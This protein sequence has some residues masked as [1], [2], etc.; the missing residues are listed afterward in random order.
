MIVDVLAYRLTEF[1]IY[2]ACLHEVE[3]LGGEGDHAHGCHEE[4]VDWFQGNILEH[5][6]NIFS[7]WHNCVCLSQCPCVSVQWTKTEHCE[8]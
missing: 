7:K 5:I 2:F 6:S 1:K 4:E 8:R 3:L